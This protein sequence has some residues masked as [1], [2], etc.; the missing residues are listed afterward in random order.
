M[1]SAVNASSA[2]SVG[3]ALIAALVAILGV[4]GFQNRRTK[5]SAIR[6]AF[7]DVVGSLASDEPRRQ[8]AAAILL[9]RFFDPT[10]ELGVRDYIGRRRAPYSG[11]ALS[12]MAAVLRGL[13]SGD[14]QKVLADGLAYAPTLENADLQRTNLYGSYLP[15]RRPDGNLERADFYRADLSGSSLKNARAD[16]AFFYQARLRGTVLQKAELRNADFF[17][18]DVTGANFA[19][20]HLKGAKFRGTRGFP[21][22]LKQYLDDDHVYTADVPA[23]VPSP[24][25]AAAQ[26]TV[27]LSLP[28]H[29][30]ASQEAIC[31]RVATL[32]EKEGLETYRLA[33]EEYPPSDA[34]GEI[35]RRLLGCAGVVVLGLRANESSKEASSSGATP[36]THV[37]AG[38]AYG[39]DIPLLMIR[40]TGVESGAFEN[41]VAGHRVYLIDLSDQ[42][43]DALIAQSMRPWLS[44][45]SLS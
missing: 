20:A 2:I 12:V 3:S 37:E 1:L 19:G 15:L 33:R 36:W 38:M 21:D 32:L 35:R 18:A 24:E 45:L 40:E 29:R 26:L 41:S 30:T 22:E 13:P 5:L 4:V 7:N 23:P 10:S 14:L 28:S 34:L 44:E 8:L 25:V 42:W 27:F 9:R 31:D 17:E 11:E 6:T 43:E 39:C 16:G